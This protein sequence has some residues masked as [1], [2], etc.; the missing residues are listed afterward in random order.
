MANLAIPII[1]ANA[2]LLVAVQASADQG[3]ATP[4]PDP[5]GPGPAPEPSSPTPPAL[6]PP[7]GLDAASVAHLGRINPEAAAFFADMFA[8]ASAADLAFKII[9]SKR[10]CA[11]QN[12]LYAQGRTKPG[13]VVTYARGCQSWHVAGRAIDVHLLRNETVARLT[14]LGQL[15]KDAGGKWGGDFPGF[16]D[17]VHFEF[18]PGLTIRDVCP[19]PDHC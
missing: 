17:L 13:Q 14:A 12:A 3:D 8:R 10:T 19:D 16:P 5:P 11:E 18:H 4:F 7:A 9:S 1:L 2:L 15:C 6:A